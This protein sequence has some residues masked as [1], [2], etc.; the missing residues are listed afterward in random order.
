[1][2]DIPAKS[3]LTYFHSARLLFLSCSLDFAN[4]TMQCMI[5]QCFN[6]SFIPFNVIFIINPY[7]FCNSLCSIWFTINQAGKPI[8]EPGKMCGVSKLHWGPMASLFERD[9]LDSQLHLVLLIRNRTTFKYLIGFR[10]IITSC[11]MPRSIL[12]TI[13][14]FFNAWCLIIWLS[15]HRIFFIQARP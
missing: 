14:L 10:S 12:F 3:D 4:F 13:H 9:P 2:P 7:A 15:E 11:Q 8:Q 6:C 5:F 1:M